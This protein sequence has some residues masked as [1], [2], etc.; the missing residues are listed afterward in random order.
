MECDRDGNT[1][2]SF[3]L[4][5]TKVAPAGETVACATQD[6][7]SDPLQAFWR[8]LAINDP[9]PSEPLF[10]Y[11]LGHVRVPL[12]R[13]AF[14]RCIASAARAAGIQ[15]LPGHSLRIGSTLE[16]LLRGIPF[17][18]VKTMNRWSSNAFQLYLRKHGQILARYLQA[19]PDLLASLAQVSLPPVR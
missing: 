2:L 15:P 19:K 6:G 11:M 9:S 18:V 12:T 14:L 8:H 10:A 1:V 17:D 4:P 13:L 7:L 3:F 5:H 16:Y